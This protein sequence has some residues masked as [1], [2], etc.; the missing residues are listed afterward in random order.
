MENST[1]PH[2]GLPD[3]REFGQKIWD[4]LDDDTVLV[5]KALLIEPGANQSR[6]AALSG[7]SYRRVKP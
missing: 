6:L 7:V 1:D 4:E 2:S 3:R 5:L